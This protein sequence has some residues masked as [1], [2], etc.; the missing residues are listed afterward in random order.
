MPV[1]DLAEI[2]EAAGFNVPEDAGMLARRKPAV[3]RKAEPNLLAAEETAKPDQAESK[4]EA[5]REKMFTLPGRPQLE[6]FFNE[7]VIDIIFNSEKCGR[8]GSS[9]LPP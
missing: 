7:H 8:W 9:F 6:E 5:A 4:T 2:V 3:F 1:A